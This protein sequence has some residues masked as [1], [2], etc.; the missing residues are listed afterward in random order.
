MFRRIAWAAP[1]AAIALLPVQAA[2]FD[3]HLSV[4]ST[5]FDP[6]GMTGTVAVTGL[7]AGTTYVLVAAYEALPE[8]ACSA[9]EESC[10]MR[11]LQGQYQAGFTSCTGGTI[12]GGDELI[13]PAG[14][15]DDPRMFP[16]MSSA[17]AVHPQAGSQ[18]VECTYTLRQVGGSFPPGP[19]DAVRPMAWLLAGGAPVARLT[20]PRVSMSETVP[21][22][23]IPEAPLP[24]LLLIAALGTTAAAV[25][26]TRIR[27]SGGGG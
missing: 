26:L 7:K 14:R 11:V 17:F 9:S 2:A 27:L 23:T 3:G 19:V 8:P 21:P 15:V 16:I 13:G 12:A 18:S 5:A 1:L 25:L 10:S 4:S 20:G 22:P 24:I 6:P